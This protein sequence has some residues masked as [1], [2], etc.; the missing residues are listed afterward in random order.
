MAL[1]IYIYIKAL[2]IAVKFFST[3]RNFPICICPLVFAFLNLY[4][5]II[6]IQELINKSNTVKSWVSPW[7]E[8]LLCRTV[9]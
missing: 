3:Y 1:Y 9:A 8:W 6:Y 2:A 5:P 7:G 4:V